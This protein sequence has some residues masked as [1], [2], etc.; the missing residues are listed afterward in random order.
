[1]DS[2]NF[3][4]KK[5]AL[6]THFP[7]VQIPLHSRLMAAFLIFIWGL[8]FVPGAQAI[9]SK[10]DLLRQKAEQSE[11]AEQWEQASA[12][13]ADLF[14]HDRGQFDSL[15][16]R[17]QTCLRHV[18]QSRRHH[19]PAFRERVL[20]K[21]V[22]GALK[23]YEEVLTKLQAN[24]FLKD[25]VE[26]ARLF[27]HGLDELAMDLEDVF[28]R[29]E[30][31]NSVSAS[32]MEA[33]RSWLKE[34]SKPI[35]D[36][37]EAKNCALEVALEAQKAVDLKPALVIVELACGA[38]NALDEYTMFLTPGMLAE[39]YASLEGRS[40]GI[41]IEVDR[42]RPGQPL[43]IAQILKNSPAETAGLKARDRIIRIDRLLTDK[44]TVEQAAEKLKGD[45]GSSV[46]LEVA[47][48]GQMTP[49]V[50][51]LVR[52]AVFV[53]S[54]VEVQMLDEHLGLGYFQLVG[55]QET[56]LAEIDEAVGQL[57]MRG[58][59]V[60]ILDLRGNPGGL[61]QIAVQVAERF[62]TAGVIVATESQV[63][64]F[65][66]TYSA[67]NAEAWGV[68]L[69]LLI[70]NETASAAEVIAGAFRD[71]H[72]ATLVGQTTFGKGSVQYV[73]E[74][75]SMLGGIRITQAR[76]F[77]PRGHFYGKGGVAPHIPVER[78]SMMAFD[79]AQLQAAV[80]AAQRLVMMTG[81]K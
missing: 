63:A 69:V 37:T 27:R 61:F 78:T 59:K 24:Y 7:S 40:I 13:Y 39:T 60:L 76:F 3:G 41:G 74:L 66:K 28:F 44:L 6:F 4:Q 48:T 35:H 56:T 9:D 5:K 50:L 43:V 17:Y 21:D 10:L 51:T 75:S 16:D 45:V 38:C 49:R 22:A 65:N 42:A 73:V 2:R 81:M 64:T 25:K 72:R 26:F 67:N 54:V 57:Q 62:L 53:P 47:Q 31:L 55:F 79:E 12:L 19:E 15:K 1:L 71:H 30:Y 18:Y 46:E 23:V 20:H 8:Y 11:K 33:F 34:K 52:Q 14:S 77:S 29:R 32:S 80:S 68:P 58:M 70:D 36:L